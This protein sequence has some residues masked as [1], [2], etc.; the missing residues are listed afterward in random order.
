MQWKSRLTTLI[1]QS[2]SANKDELLTKETMYNR[3]R[4]ESRMF[5][6]ENKHLNKYKEEADLLINNLSRRNVMLE[7]ELIMRGNNDSDYFYSEKLI[8]SPPKSPTKQTNVKLDSVLDDDL[9]LD[10]NFV[11]RE[12][13]LRCLDK[14]KR[15]YRKTCNQGT[16]TN[17]KNI[18][19]YV[20]AIDEKDFERYKQENKF[21]SKIC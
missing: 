19:K 7:D 12:A 8:G 17:L 9:E 15:M 18:D 13:S 2:W 20:V 14:V 6:E 1:K 16:I 3:L 10:S 4:E 5:Q 21:R 11:R